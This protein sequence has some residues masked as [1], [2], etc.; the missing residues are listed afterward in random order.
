MPWLPRLRAPR[1]L[2]SPWQVGVLQVRNN[3]AQQAVLV[4]CAAQYRV[5][6]MLSIQQGGDG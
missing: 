5:I 3:D 2:Q 6:E 4:A 1:R